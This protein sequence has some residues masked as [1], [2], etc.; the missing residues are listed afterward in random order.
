M[1]GTT[2]PIP[3]RITVAT[4]GAHDLPRLRAFY[5]GLGWPEKPDS[6]D[7]TGRFTWDRER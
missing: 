6:T 2:T 1:R 5:R 7:A 4:I 3:A